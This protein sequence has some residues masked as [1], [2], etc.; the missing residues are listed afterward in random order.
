MT[1]CDIFDALTASDR[2]DK[3]AMPVEKALQ[4]LEWEAKDGML[5]PEIVKLFAAS[6]VYHKILD[7]DWREF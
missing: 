7:R 5:E 2:P 3:K 6:G 1:V 4:I